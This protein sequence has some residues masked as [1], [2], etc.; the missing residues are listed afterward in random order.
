MRILLPPSEGKRPGGRGKSLAARAGTTPIDQVRAQTLAA[1]ADLVERP[2]AA[3][4]L[5]LPASVAAQALLDNRRVMSAG[6]LPAVER[7]AGVVYDG[8]AI[9][10]MS[11]GAR[12]RASRV[13]LIFSGLFGVLR[14]GDP[15]PNYRVPAKAVLP[16]IGVAGTFWRRRLDVLVPD[17]LDRG[18]I[19]DLRSSDY[20]AMWQPA[21][22]SAA[23]A[24]L[25]NVRILSATP[26]GRLAVVSYNSK[27]AKGKLAA[28]VLEAEA[29]G[30]RI[31]GPADIA[32]L[33][34]EL[35]G[36]SATV[37]GSN[38]ELVE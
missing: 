14:G 7:Y 20:A 15:V 1:L 33:W 34:S 9:D 16:G 25:I 4:K 28:A 19:L 38:L 13:L 27:L 26:S 17:L 11:D 10:S 3:E 35:G 22:G 24:Q 6:T 36:R 12:R 2:D 30:H 5:L 37:D 31:G 21:R 8:L 29:A 18:P 23:A 32:T